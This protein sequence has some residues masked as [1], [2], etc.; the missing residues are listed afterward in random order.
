MLT[1]LATAAQFA[2]FMKE[3][4]ASDD[5]TVLL[6]LSIAEAMV[7]DALGQFIS[8]LPGDVVL[9][10]PINGAGFLPELPVKKVQRVEVC[11]AGIWS[12]ADPST[13]A[14]SR[15]TGVIT[16]LSGST[17]WPTGPES[18]RV[19][20]DHGYDPVPITLTSVV[21]GVA[22]RAFVSPVGIDSERLGGYQ[23][24]YQVEAAGFSPLEQV[25]LDAYRLARVA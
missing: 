16:A 22:A 8:F 21:L 3:P 24:K 11:N 23:V 25:A 9:L 1:S 18:W 15:R 14:L 4:V 10:D 20:Y 17:V 13:F 12:D 19:T 2:I 7:R 5:P 6:L